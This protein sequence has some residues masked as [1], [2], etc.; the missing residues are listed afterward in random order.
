MQGLYPLPLLQGGPFCL[1]PAALAS[2]H[3]PNASPAHGHLLTSFLL[4]SSKQNLS[5]SD[6]ANQIILELDLLNSSFRLKKAFLGIS[7]R[8]PMFREIEL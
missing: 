8:S 6:S 7:V 4:L 3:T 2:H 1:I 5:K